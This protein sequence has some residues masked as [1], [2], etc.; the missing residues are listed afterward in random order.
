MSGLCGAGH[1]PL[2]V[3]AKTRCVTSNLSACETGGIFVFYLHGQQSRE[4]DLWDGLGPLAAPLPHAAPPVFGELRLLAGL[5]Q[6]PEPHPSLLPVVQ[7]RGLWLAGREQ[8]CEGILSQ[9]SIKLSSVVTVYL[10][11]TLIS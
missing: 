7:H 1:E 2:T 5:H 3:S 8:V 11:S 10:L 4:V 9:F 6:V